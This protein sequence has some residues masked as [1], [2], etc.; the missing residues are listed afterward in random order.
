MT[1]VVLAKWIATPEEEEKVANAISKLI[2]PSRAEAG[3]LVYRAHR[4]L[5][6]PRVF[7]L[8]EEYSDQA[9]YAAHGA[10]EH[11]RR[12]AIEEGIPLLETR[13]VSFYEPL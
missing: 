10:S 3:C 6:D 2:A 8:Y 11:F 5:D 4:D 7:L 12:H 9:A 13:A 1:Y